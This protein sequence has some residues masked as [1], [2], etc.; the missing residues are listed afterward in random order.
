M[1]RDLFFPNR[2][3]TCYTYTYVTMVRYFNT[4]KYKR[5]PK[6]TTSQLHTHISIACRQH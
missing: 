5:S 4:S 3:Y 6:R 2:T 1:A